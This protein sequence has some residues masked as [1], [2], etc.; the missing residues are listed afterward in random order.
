MLQEELREENAI[1]KNSNNVHKANNTT[2][3]NELEAQVKNLQKSLTEANRKNAEKTKEIHKLERQTALHTVSEMGQMTEY[4]IDFRAENNSNLNWELGI[5]DDFRDFKRFVMMEFQE[6]KQQMAE[7]TSDKNKQQVIHP[8]LRNNET[9]LNTKLSRKLSY[10][11]QG[12]LTK[13]KERKKRKWRPF[14]VINKYPERDMLF[15]VK[16]G[17]VTYNEAVQLKKKVAIICD[18]MP[19]SITFRVQ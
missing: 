17:A 6:I 7:I 10:I 15:Q 5:Y 3:I 16:P 2:K 14:P 12:T 11:K 18:S 13:D 19:K 4:D 8:T 9:F 1:I